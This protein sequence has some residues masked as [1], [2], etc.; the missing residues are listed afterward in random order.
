MDTQKFSFLTVEQVC[1][2]LNYTK[3]Y[4]YQLTHRREIP[5]YKPRGGKLLFDPDELKAWVAAG[6]VST[7]GEL[8][9][10]AD[11]LLNRGRV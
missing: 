11:A 2:I 1:S 6:K 3:S 9:D 8:Q 10:R 4:V 7:V 5:F